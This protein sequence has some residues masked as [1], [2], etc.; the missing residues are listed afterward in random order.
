VGFKKKKKKK[1]KNKGKVK[2]KIIRPSDKLFAS[3]NLY[4]LAL[5]EESQNHSWGL[6]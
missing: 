3:E 4:G 5:C 1:K 6:S 2:Q